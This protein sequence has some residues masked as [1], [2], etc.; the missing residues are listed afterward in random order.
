MQQKAAH[1]LSIMLLREKQ[2]SQIVNLLIKS[3]IC[4]SWQSMKIIICKMK[5][6][7]NCNVYIIYILCI[8]SILNHDIPERRL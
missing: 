5:I 4:P 8:I 2:E 3:Q 6:K 1:V 7:F